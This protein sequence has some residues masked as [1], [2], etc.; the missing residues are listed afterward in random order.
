M[1]VV[2]NGG[3]DAMD[4]AAK[5]PGPA[6]ATAD[7]WHFLESGAR[8]PA[9]NMALDEALLEHAALVGR[10]V[11][12]SY[13]WTV[14][15]ATFGYSQRHRDI[16]ALTPLRPLLRRPTG[17]GLV[18]HAA[19]WTYSVVVPPGHAWHGLSA[20]ESYAR[21]HA[22]LRDA[23]A[24]LGFPTR[25][26]PCPNPTG[27]GQCFVGWEESDL[28]RGETKLAG[29]AQR[30]NRS[31]L[32]IQGSLQPVPAD[33]AREEFFGAMRSVATRRWEASWEPLPDGEWNRRAAELAE[34]KYARAEH[35]EG[36]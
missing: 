9:W 5:T 23:F 22:W 32:L 13:A 8:D 25:L 29:A 27:P 6:A 28:L 16:G 30:R 11:L 4:P 10:P 35:N 19:D 33:V 24:A 7:R 2:L 14:P 34:S 3:T 15:A 26:A 17:G 21:M 20:K 1:R 36:R 18:P 31:G 12:R